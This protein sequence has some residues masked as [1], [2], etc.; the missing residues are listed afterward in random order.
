MIF[1]EF[2]SACAAKLG[3]QLGTHIAQLGCTG[4]RPSW[5]TCIQARQFATTT[6]KHVANLC[7]HAWQCASKLSSVHLSCATCIQAGQRASKLVSMH[8]NYAQ[9]GRTNLQ[10]VSRQLLQ[11]GPPWMGGGDGARVP[12]AMSM[13]H[14]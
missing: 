9:E 10:Y 4:G 11:I 14:G 13:V 6:G 3:A 7:T 2:A 8:P 12:G 5:A 1:F